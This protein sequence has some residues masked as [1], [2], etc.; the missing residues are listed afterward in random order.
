ML[1]QHLAVHGLIS[2][3]ISQRQQNA[4]LLFFCQPA[5]ACCRLAYA[6]PIHKTGIV[7]PERF[8]WGIHAVVDA[9]LAAG[10]PGMRP[11]YRVRRK[12]KKKKMVLTAIQSEACVYQRK[13]KEL[14]QSLKTD[15]L[16]FFKGNDDRQVEAASI[17]T[18]IVCLFCFPGR[19]Q[20]R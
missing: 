3:V 7:I 10:R 9:H 15:V 19:P 12:T 1:V 4:G 14:K 11:S 6:S 20:P 8:L 17:R 5:R 16:F 18:C 2:F 13:K